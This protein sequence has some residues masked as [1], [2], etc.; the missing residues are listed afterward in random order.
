M[1]RSSKK[2]PS[3]SAPAPDAE[4]VAAALA[5]ADRLQRMNTFQW[6]GLQTEMAVER[7]LDMCAPGRGA[8]APRS[9]R[10]QKGFGHARATAALRARPGGVL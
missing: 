6:L 7:G 10:T 9:A 8:R 2:I 4:A 3:T 1:G 5:E